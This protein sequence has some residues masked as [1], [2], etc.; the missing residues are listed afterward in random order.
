MHRNIKN[1]DNTL[2]FPLFMSER[3]VEKPD[4]WGA[5]RWL[6]LCTLKGKRGRAR[7]LLHL[8]WTGITV[9]FHSSN[10]RE[11]VEEE[12]DGHGS[13]WF[14]V[15]RVWPGW[16]SSDCTLPGLPALVISETKH[17]LDIFSLKLYYTPRRV[18][19][20]ICRFFVVSHYHCAT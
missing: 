18:H 2:I 1:Y 8:L 5:T 15:F 19:I 16:I 3:L 4:T 9:N 6:G 17:Y 7:L 10:T 12:K 14:F 13:A 11:T 20:F